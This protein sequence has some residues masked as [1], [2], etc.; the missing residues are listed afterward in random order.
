MKWTLYCLFILPFICLSYQTN[1]AGRFW[2]A[3]A[4]SNWNNIANWSNAANG[5]GGFSV[6]VAGDAVSFT[7]NGLGNCTIDIAVN[8]QN[9]TVNA[10]YTGTISQN[11][12]TIS[13]AGAANFSGGV[14]IGGS[15]NITIGGIFTLAGTAFT[16]TTAVLEMDGNAVFTSA[17]F[18][19]NN[20]TVSFNGAGGTTISGTNPTF[21][22]LQFV[23]NGGAYNITSAGSLTVL[24]SLNLTGTQLYNLNTGTINVNGDINVT[25]TAGGCG[26]TALINIDGAGVQNFNG[27]AVAGEGALP[28]LT[29]NKAS[30]TL[31]LANFP[32]SSNNFTYTAGV[33]N[34]GTSTFCFTDGSA[35]PYTVSGSPNLNNITF[36][37]LSNTTFTLNAA[38]PLTAMGVLTM[39]GTN[40]IS[41]NTGTIN[42]NGDIILTNTSALGGGTGTITING[43]GNQNMDG[44]AI[45]IQQDPLAYIII[46]KAG[47]TL[48]LKGN[49]TESQDWTYTAGTVDA[50]SFT[51]TVAFGGNALNVTSAGMNFYNF[52]CFGNTITLLT[53]LTVNNNITITGGKLMPV[54]NTINIA[55]NWNDYSA[56]GFVNATSTVNFDGAALQTITNP[57]G[58]NY[59]NF[60]VN[61]SGAGIQLEDV[62]TVSDV[63]TMTQGNIDLNSNNFT[64]GT[65]AVAANVGTLAYS[66]G[67][68]LNTGS[69][70]RWFAKAV[71]AAGSSAGLFPVGTIFNYTPFYISA[72]TAP[73]TGGTVTVSFAAANGSTLVSFP[74][75]ASTVAVIDNLNWDLTTGNGLAGGSYNLDAQG[76]GFGTIGSIAD[77]RLTLVGSVVGVAGVNAGTTADP[78]VNRTGLTVANLTNDFYMGSVNAVNS[79]LPLT[80]LS[81]TASVVND[82]V[83]LSWSTAAQTN[84]ASFSIQRSKDGANWETLQQIAGAGASDLTNFYSTTDQSPYSGISYYRLIQTGLDGYK[85]YSTICA[86]SIQNANSDISISPIPAINTIVITF[87]AAGNYSV[88][89]LNSAGQSITKP[90]QGTAGN[91]SLNVSSIPEGIYF[92][93]IN[94]EN[95]TETREVAIWR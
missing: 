88:R 30:G 62:V 36:L 43:G 90:V 33:I 86:V 73:T 76:T 85:T 21:F 91:V 74:D 11:A 22:V 40:R 95:H 16:S 45:P 26:G 32:A 58:E 78:Q 79:P 24:S 4:A 15:A 25:N 35:S 27:A 14:F 54:A 10:G 13:T 67:T 37:T 17:T 1:A 75:G 44:T 5:A 19:H 56:A 77:L 50:T 93:S 51:S 38:T 66:S 2:V 47:G 28:Q 52:T 31:N 87:P 84:S 63:L 59:N 8:V 61:N 65:S 20:G 9:I 80:L 46:N 6:P 12:N 42:A 39:A 72:P 89:L 92:L 49:I 53:S 70:T 18:T 55:G 48:T 83:V 7:A 94:Y 34:P 23:G 82:R 71:I 57:G 3:A 60:T 41:I 68:M 69:F 81:F 29:I 64:L